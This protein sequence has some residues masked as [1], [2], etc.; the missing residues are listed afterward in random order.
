L[1][2]NLPEDGRKLHQSVLTG[3]GRCFVP[4]FDSCEPERKGACR[5]G[6]SEATASL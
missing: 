2:A 6:P 1:L 5:G 4:V 3:K